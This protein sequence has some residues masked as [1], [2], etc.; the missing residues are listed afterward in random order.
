MH[1]KQGPQQESGRFSAFRAR[2]PVKIGG[3]GYTEAILQAARI[4]RRI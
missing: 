1:S 2:P 3:G 4:A